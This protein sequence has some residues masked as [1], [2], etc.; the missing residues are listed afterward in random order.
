MTRSS[1]NNSIILITKYSM[2]IISENMIK[3][4]LNDNVRTV[5]LPLGRRMTMTERRRSYERSA[6]DSVADDNSPQCLTWTKDEPWW[7]SLSSCA[8]RFPKTIFAISQCRITRAK[9]CRDL[10]SRPPVHAGV[11]D[12]VDYEGNVAAR[13]GKTLA[14]VDMFSG[15]TYGLDI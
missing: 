5:S 15:A 6:A 8:G 3:T 13:R 10:L 1:I 9:G 4:E 7:R 12:E 14:R 11:R 2:I